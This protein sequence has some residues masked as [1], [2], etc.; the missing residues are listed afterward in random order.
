[1]IR[2]YEIPHCANQQKINS[3]IDLLPYYNSAMTIVKQWKIAD[4]KRGE[5]VQRYTA[6]IWDS[7]GIDAIGFSRRQLKSIENQVNAAIRSWI[8]VSIPLG[9]ACI[10]ALKRDGVLTDGQAHTLYSKNVRRLWWDDDMKSVREYI[11]KRNKFPVF[12]RNRT[13]QLDEIVAKH[14]TAEHERWV[15]IN[16]RNKKRV[17]IPLL[18]S[19]YFNEKVEKGREAQV[20]SVLIRDNDVRFFRPVHFEDAVP[21]TSGASVGIDW[22]MTSLLTL[23]TGEKFGEEL[24]EWLRRVDQQ[25]QRLLSELQKRGIKPSKSKRFRN[26]Q[27]RIR[28]TFKNAIGKVFNELSRRDIQ[29]IALEALDFRGGGLSRQMNRLVSRFARKAF[30]DKARS[31]KEEY[32]IDVVE[33]NPAYSSRECPEC[34]ST[35]KKNRKRIAF[36]CISCG[37]EADADVNA[38]QNILR[39]SHDI[40]AFNVHFSKHRI[41]Q[42]LND[43]HVQHLSSA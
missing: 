6:D 2:S 43:L 28:E 21:R 22:G 5:K 37:Y 18:P 15:T 38:A 23:S 26:F 42:H 3:L 40:T 17:D 32:G 24:L 12:S 41:Q 34:H 20:T 30:S 33:V 4:L 8:E 27:N 16:L 25:S 9:R 31:L 13:I 39:R 14:K 19:D 11:L 29:K 10:L 7:M 35:D 1:M 36:K